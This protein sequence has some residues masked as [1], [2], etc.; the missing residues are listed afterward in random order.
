MLV[1]LGPTDPLPLPKDVIIF[2]EICLF[3]ET[4][5][6]KLVKGLSGLLADPS[7]TVSLK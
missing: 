1:M 4:P 5:L 2:G 3:G 6:A 7:R